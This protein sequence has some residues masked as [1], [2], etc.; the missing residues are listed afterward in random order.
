MK[1]AA[2]KIFVLAVCIIVMS[3]AGCGRQE[4]PSVKKSR[5]IAVEN[6][7][8]KRELE[9]RDREIEK[10]IEQH[11]KEIK[12]Q[13]E[14]LAKCVRE[15][16]SWKQKAQQNVRNQVKGVFDAV[17]EQNAKLREENKKLKAEMEKLQ[18]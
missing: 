8:L 18:K 14:L 15:K 12:K 2:R 9:Q 17:M 6:M 13:E 16:D 3:I 11:N 1:R 4:L 7:Q 5:L 10:L